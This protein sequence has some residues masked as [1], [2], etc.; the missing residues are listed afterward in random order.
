MALF[1]RCRTSFIRPNFHNRRGLCRRRY[2]CASTGFD[3]GPS[4]NPSAR[5][6]V[7]QDP[8]ERQLAVT[9]GASCRMVAAT[10]P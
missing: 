1:C 8:I 4:L 6:A 10:L 2:P 3:A 9:G 7:N 5:R